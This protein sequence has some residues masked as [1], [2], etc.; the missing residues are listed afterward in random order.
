MRALQSDGGDVII[1]ICGKEVTVYLW[2][3]VT[4]RLSAPSGSR[5]QLEKWRGVQFKA[6][7]LCPNFRHQKLLRGNYYME[8]FNTTLMNDVISA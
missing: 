8:D 4:S 6:G 5:N 1:I 3:F 7:S 2:V